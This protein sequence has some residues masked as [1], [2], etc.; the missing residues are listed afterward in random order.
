MAGIIL[1]GG[2]QSV[3]DKNSPQADKDILELGIPVLGICYGHQWLAHTLGG[4]VHGGKTKE[5]GHTEIT[6]AQGGSLFKGLPDKFVVWMSHGDEV[7]KL[8]EGFVTAATTDNCVNAAMANED[9]KMFGVQ[10]HPESVLS[11]HGHALLKNFLDL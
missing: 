1:S 11:E 6:V 2:P 10:F 7:M 8:P 5:Y 3:Y 4:E 9:K